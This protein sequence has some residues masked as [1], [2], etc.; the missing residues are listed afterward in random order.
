MSAELHNLQTRKNIGKAKGL[1]HSLVPRAQ[2]FCYYDTQRQCLWS[3]DGA[4]DYE[5]DNFVADLPEEII[6]GSESGAEIIRRTLKSGRTLLVLPVYDGNKLRLGLLVAVFSRNAGK[7]SSFNPRMLVNILRPA[8][9]LIGESLVLG[10]QVQDAEHQLEVLEKEL[11]LVYEVDDKIHGTARSHAGFAQLVGQSGR[12]LGIA[13]TVLLIPG[14]RIRVSATHSSWKNVNRKVVDRYLIDHMLP[15]L[16]GKRW[17]AVFE[18]AG[19]DGAEN[20]PG[21]HFQT[22]L[23]PLYDRHGNLEGILAQLGR[24]DRGTFTTA[25]RRFMAHIMRKVE[26]VIEQS[27]DSMTGLMNRSG[28][29]TQLHESAKSLTG[30]DDRHQLIYI[31]L[32]N[33]QLVNDTFDRQAGDAVIVRFARLLEDGI[34]RNAV[35]SRLA[36]DEFCILLTS[37]DSDQAIEL[38]A[39]LRQKGQALRYLEGD[40][41]LQVTM[42]IGIAEFGSITADVGQALTMARMACE[43]AKAHGR[44]RIEVYDDQNL[45]MI[46]RHDDMQLISQIQQALDGDQFELLAQPISSLKNSA[47]RPRFEILL[48][49]M[50][51]EGENVPSRAFFSAAERYQLMPQ[52]D[53]WVVSAVIA[54]LAAHTDVIEENEAIFS[55]N[56]S[57]QSLGDD[58]ILEFIDE[59]LAASS[60]SPGALG[61]EITESAAVSNLIKA[62]AFIDALR[63][64]GCTISLD[65]FGSGLSSFA[66]LKNFSVDTLKID[67]N[68]IRD[69]TDNRI[70]ESMVAA[71]TQVAK[72][73]ELE[74]VAEYV[75]SEETLGLLAKLGVDFAQG[76]VIGKPVPIADALQAMT[77]KAES[78][79]A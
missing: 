22:L 24:I 10:Q 60:L 71:I 49:M 58:H 6:V 57:G 30:A 74:T 19:I 66:Y 26:Y 29:E 56:L 8:V 23:C 38:A 16:E 59:E 64:R 40:R 48:R 67:G 35:V 53:R 52:I 33:L 46:R 32:D 63:E 13:Y 36:G 15:K 3:S 37:A 2:C 75:E 61:F 47:C 78:S 77:K 27:F 11:K 1:L 28:F 20:A 31:D 12:F 55:V 7:S 41:S 73:M 42:S 54:Q 25:E 62:Q 51:G 4:E 18:I 70:S 45:S 76:H 5:I 50:G 34:S 43:G 69:I 21:S 65:D 14:K 39:E 72:V 9:D 68:F 44:D 17:P 79:T